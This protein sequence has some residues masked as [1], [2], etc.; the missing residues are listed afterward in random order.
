MELLIQKYY[1]VDTPIVNWKRSISTQE[2]KHLLLIQSS[3][4]LITVN[5]IVS[6]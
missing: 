2:S 3:L 5:H 6:K 1:V 4:V